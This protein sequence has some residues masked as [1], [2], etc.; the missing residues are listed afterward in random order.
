M[1]AP[2]RGAARI[3]S[4]VRSAGSE[5]RGTR[6]DDPWLLILQARRKARR[7]AVGHPRPRLRRLWLSR[8]SSS[9]WR[10]SSSAAAAATSTRFVFQNAGQLVPDNQ[11]LIGG[12]PVGTVESIDLTDDNLAEVNVEVDQQLH[13]GTTRDDPRHLALRASPTT[14]SRSARGR[15]AAR[16]WTT[17]PTS[18]SP[19][20]RPR[21]TS[22]SSSTPSRRRS[23]RAC[24][25]FIKGNAAIYAGQGK[26]GQRSLQVLRPGAQPDRR[27]R[28]GTE[29]RPAAAGTLPRQLQQISRP[30]S[31]SA[32]SS[33][34]AR[35]P[36]PARPSARSPRQN[37]ALDQSLRRLPPVLRQSNTTF[38]NLRAALDDLDPLVNTAKPA[39]KNLA[40]VPGR[41]APGRCRN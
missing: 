5:G 6:S 12:S 40:P 33:S 24:S 25:N 19:R 7:R 26:A 17:G 8:W 30:P 11:V 41:T 29:R 4:A 20:P 36:T 32:A 27:L 35:S 37:V 13:E 15:T 2:W 23:A 28:Q 38:V 34:P 21:S 16:S 22:T 39:T 10:S 14:T 9:P 1:H 31:P 3:R 18:G